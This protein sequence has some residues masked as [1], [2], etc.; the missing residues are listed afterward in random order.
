M[1]SR[2][3]RTARAHPAPRA[4]RKGFL[5]GFA[6][7][8]GLR[9]GPGV[10]LA[11]PEPRDEVGEALQLALARTLRVNRIT[12]T[13]AVMT[14]L[15]TSLRAEFLELLPRFAPPPPPAPPAP[16]AEAAPTF[17]PA[18][19]E[20]GSAEVA[21]EP[22]APV[23]A[24]IP[25][26]VFSPTLQER[27]WARLADEIGEHLLLPFARCDVAFEESFELES[28]VNEIV[29]DA[30]REA[31]LVVERTQRP[32]LSEGADVLRRRVRKLVK[33]V[34]ELRAAVVQARNAKVIDPG[35]ASIYRTVQGLAES[36]QL[37]ELKR[38]MLV[39][40]FETN[41]RLRDDLRAHEGHEGLGEAPVSAP[42]V[43]SDAP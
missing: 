18:V 31:S 12:L 7:A 5:V 33:A 36:D 38:E 34:R 4:P 3:T 43:R 42:R 16:P 29:V 20:P 10:A 6:D 1:K 24:P 26:P 2:W 22:A 9:G 28:R 25:L 32:P 39:D 21:A 37:A 27:L 13:P 35:L 14:A 8:I 11:E 30:A 40:V 41:L 23:R 17:D 19:G 15:R